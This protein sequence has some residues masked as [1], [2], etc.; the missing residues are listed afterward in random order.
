[1][2]I[3]FHENFLNVR[4]TSVALF[5]YA[6]FNEKILGNKSIIIANRNKSNDPSVV[7]KFEEHFEVLFY[8]DFKEI[9]SIVR[10]RNIDVVYIIKSGEND[11]MIVPNVKNVIHS[12]FCG[13]PSQKHGNVYAT[14]SEWLSSLSN[15]QIPYVPH[16]I[17]LP[18]I[19]SDLR[20]D[21]SI[22]NNA[23]VVGRY[24]GIETFDIG[25]VH[26]SIKKI[27]NER[28]DI[29]FLFM[30]TNKF[31]EHKR[32]I[33]LGNS[34]S[35]EFKVNFI[36]TCDAMI[37]ARLQGESFGLSVLEFACKNKQIITFG[38]SREKSHLLYLDG[39]CHVY[40]NQTELNMI[41][42]KLAK[43]NPFDTT[44]LNDKFSPSN[45]MNSFKTV[46]LND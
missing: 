21:L 4:G 7:E 44:Y 19:D 6:Y 42:T 40:N 8:N 35:L 30:N 43:A 24:G 46:F 34:P 29:Y 14:V 45:V 37:H 17:N 27:L 1:M 38:G 23:L 33:F 16:M 25:F 12:V 15:N 28:D 13:N 41:F 26:D 10:D 31:I 2:I 5:D 32:V 36:N 22:P 18:N 9:E 11:G 39:N 20:D 3:L